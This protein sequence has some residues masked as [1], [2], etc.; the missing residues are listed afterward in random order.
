MTVLTKVESRPLGGTSPSNCEGTVGQETS[1]HCDALVRAKEEV[2]KLRA[3]VKSQA[4]II[5]K[6]GIAPALVDYALD[7]VTL[8]SNDRRVVYANAS[9]K[10]MSGFGDSVVGRNLAEFYDPVNYARLEAEILPALLN[11][12]TWS[13]TLRVRRPD[14]NEWLAQTSA[15]LVRDASGTATGMAGF[16]RDVTTN[17]AERLQLELQTEL[18]ET[19]QRALRA[20]GTPLLPIADGVVAM[21]LIGDIDDARAAQIRAAL[22]DGIASHHA[23]VAIL[24]ITGVKLIDA[25]IANALVTAAKAAR[26]LGVEILMTGISPAVAKTLVEIGAELSG[27]VTRGTLQSGIAYALSYGRR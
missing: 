9:F 7:G 4:S 8:T 10:T 14:G 27:I 24:D 19:Q 25:E 23:R 11:T 12:G 22:I 3:V 18:V 20:L 15:F 26:L 21:P 5:D 2:C 1:C 13:G 17:V 16:Y 6:L